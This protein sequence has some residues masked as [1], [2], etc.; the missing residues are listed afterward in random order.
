MVGN[1]NGFK[2]AAE[3]SAI[4]VK[5]VMLLPDLL[6]MGR[7]CFHDGD[8][9][10]SLHSLFCNADDRFLLT[11]QETHHAMWL[12]CMSKVIAVGAQFCRS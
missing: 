12:A 6:L 9:Y 11:T 4:H 8:I 5:V 7:A 3:A 10:G 2:L 1:D